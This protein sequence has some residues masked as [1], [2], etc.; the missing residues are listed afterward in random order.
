MPRVIVPGEKHRSTIVRRIVLL[1]RTYNPGT[2][3]YGTRNGDSVSDINRK[4]A[5][6]KRYCEK[7]N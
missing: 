6:R 1:R 5:S 4:R 3:L 7:Q 2:G